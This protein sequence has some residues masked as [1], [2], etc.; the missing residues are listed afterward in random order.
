VHDLQTKTPTFIK[1]IWGVTI[2]LV[3]FTMISFSGIDGIKQLS[4]LGGLPILFFLVAVII[5]FV[6]MLKNYRKGTD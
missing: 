6:L 5:S 2:G 4:N 3:A 1:I